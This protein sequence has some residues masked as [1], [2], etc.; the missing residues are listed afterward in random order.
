MDRIKRAAEIKKLE[1]EAEKAEKS[2]YDLLQNIKE[3]NPDHGR[4]LV[5]YVILWFRE[6]SL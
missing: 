6:D 5:E 4:L 2:I 1:M 3:R